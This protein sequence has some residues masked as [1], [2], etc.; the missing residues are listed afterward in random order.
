MSH[1]TPYSQ[2]ADGG[3]HAQAFSQGAD[4]GSHAKAF[5]VPATTPA[6]ANTVTPIISTRLYTEALVPR[7]GG[8][9]NW[10][11][12]TYNKPDDVS[13]E[14]VVMHLETGVYHIDTEQL[15]IPGAQG[16]YANTNFPIK[17]Q[18]RAPNG[19][20]FFP[21]VAAY[22]YY[23]DPDTE[24]VQEMAKASPNES[25][26]YSARF[27][28]SG[29]LMYWGTQST[30][31][32]S[33]I[34]MV[35]TI[36]TVSLAVTQLHRLGAARGLPG[37][38]Y[39]LAADETPSVAHPSGVLYVAVGETLWEIFAVDIATGTPTSM[40]SSSTNAW[41]FLTQKPEGWICE[42]V[43]NYKKTNETRLKLWLVDGV[44]YAYADGYDPLAL[45]FT[46]RDVTPYDNQPANQPQLDETQVPKAIVWR[47]FGSTGPWTRNNFTIAYAVPVAI[48]SLIVLPD[49]TVL[50]STEN[51]AGFFRYDPNTLDV[52]TFGP[53][54]GLTEGSARVVAAGYAFLSGYPNAPNHRYNPNAA[55]NLTLGATQNPKALGNFSNGVNFS[56]VKRARQL[57]YSTPLDRLY[58]CGLRDRSGVGSGVGYCNAVTHLPDTAKVYAGTFDNLNFHGQPVG[59]VVSDV[60]DRVVF[61]GL[62]TDDPSFPGMTPTEATL[63]IYNR[64]L[65]ELE[66]VVPNAGL[67]GTGKLY[68]TATEG[69]IVGLVTILGSEQIYRYN[70]L[71]HTLLQTHVFGA[72]VTTAS[73]QDSTTFT[74]YAV[75]GGVLKSINPET[76]ALATVSGLSVFADGFFTM[77][78]P[79]IYVANAAVLSVVH[80]GQTRRFAGSLSEPIPTGGGGGGQDGGGDDGSD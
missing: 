13:S 45:P 27:G 66:R 67:A 69:V 18:L 78:G 14:W 35:G 32:N 80:R 62:M 36:D 1:S 56:G 40:G 59:M 24:I 3:R 34:P 46:P 73:W 19:R 10:I 50:G 55:W 12:Q 28:Q 20:V 8:G 70:Y 48:E 39:S 2:G 75:V 38:A 43:T 52:T 74:V 77:D 17:N 5:T 79:E 76:F 60:L 58:M 51:L 9:W 65:T 22:W 25:T 6:I 29:A 21:A 15:Y 4:S 37:F 11:G 23:F 42:I 71:T 33:N 30:V 47:D 53:Y 41:A 26:M 49:R 61:G 57:I 31:N 54:V 64:A 7:N 68:P 72:T 63:V 44:S 16:R